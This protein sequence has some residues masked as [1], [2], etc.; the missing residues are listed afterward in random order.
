MKRQGLRDVRKIAVLR[1]SA[2]GDFMFCLPALHALKQAWPEAELVY[3][4]RAWHADFLGGRPG[5][6]DRV[7][8]VPPMP[9]LNAASDAPGEP[10]AIEA[11]LGAM[12]GA[13]FDL[14]L[15]MFG[16]GRYANPLVRQFDARLTVGMRSA[17]AAPLDRSLAYAG[18]VNRRLQLLEVAALAGACAWPMHGALRVTAGDRQCAAQLVPP[19]PG[20]RLVIVQPGAS[21]LRRCWPAARF[22]ALADA[23]VE[24]GALVAVNGSAAEARLVRAVLAA[25]RHP[26]IN[27]A[28]TASL[29]ALCGLMERSVLVVSNDTGPLHMALALGRP[30]VGIYWFTNLVESAPLCQ[31]GHRAA[32]STR[33]ACPVCG[34]ENTATRCIH[35]VSFVDDVALEEVT[36]LAIDLFRASC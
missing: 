19:A 33:V 35:E 24:E 27:L 3:L 10:H 17:D 36:A 15:Q 31:H 2:L 32:L 8:V 25:M 30:C 21:D 5:P 13:G 11:F 14:A 20:Q 18:L 22:A 12:R 26:A 4:G 23:L 9:G 1:P 28:G 29:Q 6:V 34:V 16:G 7:V